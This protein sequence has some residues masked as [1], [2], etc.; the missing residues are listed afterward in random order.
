[1][2]WKSPFILALLVLGAGCQKPTP[3]VLV[4]TYAGQEGR[5]KVEL[6]LS[7]DKTFQH[8]ATIEN[9]QQDS[10]SVSLLISGTYSINKKEITLTPTKARY[11]DGD[12]KTIAALGPLPKGVLDP[13][14]FTTEWETQRDLILRS[15]VRTINLT[16]KD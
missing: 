14:T 4:G 1:M 11:S 5:H 10:R 3:P 15:T 7:E 16:R 9:S 12:A 2:N 6:T 13:M 8:K